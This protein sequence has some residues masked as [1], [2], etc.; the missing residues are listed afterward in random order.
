MTSRVQKPRNRSRS[1]TGKAVSGMVDV[2]QRSVGPGQVV[3]DP[4]CGSGT[5]GVAALALGCTFIGVE[6]DPRHVAMA[7]ARLSNSPTI[8]IT[9]PPRHHKIVRKRA[10]RRRWAK[11]FGGRSCAACGELFIP[12]EL[13]RRHAPPRAGCG[14]I[15]SGKKRKLGAHCETAF[16]KRLPTRQSPVLSS[17][18]A[19]NRAGR[20]GREESKRS[21]RACVSRCAPFVPLR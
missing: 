4:F 21:A 19:R 8:E 1:M 9:P 14:S 3:L 10:E 7:T 18:V 11:Q 6:I 16:A 17:R 12:R 15:D 20:G 5:T 13:T 2:L